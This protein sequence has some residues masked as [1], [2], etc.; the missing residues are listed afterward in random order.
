MGK[1]TEK[2]W[3]KWLKHM[4]MDQYLLIPFFVGWTSIYQL[5]WGSPGV[6]GF[7]T[8]PYGNIG[9]NGKSTYVQLNAATLG[10][11]FFVKI[12]Y[13]TWMEHWTHPKDECTYPQVTIRRWNMLNIVNIVNLG[14]FAEGFTMDEHLYLSG[15]YILCAMVKTWAR[16][17]FHRKAWSRMIINPFIGGSIPKSIKRTDSNK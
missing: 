10:L 3:E 4:G 14:L 2:G 16:S 9:K 11:F 1:I 7:D 5:F 6:Q 15:L 8:L 12:I 13:Q 17:H